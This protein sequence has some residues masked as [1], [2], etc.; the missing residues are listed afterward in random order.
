MRS[1]LI[2]LRSERNNWTHFTLMTSYKMCPQSIGIQSQTGSNDP[3]WQ[4]VSCILNRGAIKLQSQPDTAQ[5]VGTVK[6]LG[7]ELSCLSIPR[8][9]DKSWKK[10]TPRT[11]FQLAHY[12]TRMWRCASLW[13][14]WK[15]A[16]Y[17]P[18]FILRFHFGTKWE[19][20]RPAYTGLLCLP[21]DN[22]TS[23]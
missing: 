13:M 14:P 4:E 8:T 12:E 15:C 19:P 21:P 23:H 1:Q 3:W 22:L 2:L 20:M 5:S 6:V 16:L 9:E 17:P 7:S 10:E 11:W 18:F